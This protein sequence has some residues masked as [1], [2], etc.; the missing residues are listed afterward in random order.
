[1][2]SSPSRSPILDGPRFFLM[3]IAVPFRCRASWSRSAVVSI[4]P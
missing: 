1:M 3:L 2:M 4:Q